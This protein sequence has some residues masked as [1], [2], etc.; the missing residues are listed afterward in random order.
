MIIKVRLSPQGIKDAQAEL[1]QYKERV[2]K[3]LETFIARL[4]KEGYD[5]ASVKFTSA[6]YDG[7]NDVTV[8][9][10]QNGR[11]A[12]IIASGKAVLFI[13]F[14]SGVAYPVH[15]SGMYSHGTYGKGKG[16]NPTGWV[17]KGEKGTGGYPISGRSGVYRTKGNPPAEAMWDA[18]REMAERY[19]QIWLEVM[20][21]D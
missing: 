2:N 17:Y 20:R 10:E 12:K 13:E 16:A 6:L 4:V 15:A 1:K 5:I 9:V 21:G 19:R 11:G 18:T 14:G 8:R 3:R 7:D